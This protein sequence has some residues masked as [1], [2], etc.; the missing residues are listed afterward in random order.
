MKVLGRQCAAGQ[1]REAK[2]RDEEV[3]DRPH[4]SIL[5]DQRPRPSSAT[6]K[7]VQHV[8]RRFGN[9]GGEHDGT[10]RVERS[11][12]RGSER[13]LHRGMLLA[14][15]GL[16]ERERRESCPGPVAPNADRW[17]TRDGEGSKIAPLRRK[18][19]LRSLATGSNLHG[20]SQKAACQPKPRAKRAFGEGWRRERDSNPR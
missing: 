7:G 19:S 5:P 16:A 8:R 4:L 2:G 1:Q 17:E 12:R 6:T 13:C 15:G 9:A 11:R 18:R 3:V 10:T 14:K 20:R